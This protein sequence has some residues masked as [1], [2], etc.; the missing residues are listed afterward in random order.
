M[1]CRQDVKPPP[2]THSMYD[3]YVTM[4][5]F[6]IQKVYIYTQMYTFIH[7][8]IKVYKKCMYMVYVPG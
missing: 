5:G 6:N 3:S 7:N 4:K 1:I 8:C 2:L